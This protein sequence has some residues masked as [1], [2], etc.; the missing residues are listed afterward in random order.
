MAKQ[1]TTL[2]EALRPKDWIKNTFVFAGAV[3]T[4][5]VLVMDVLA[6]VLAGFTLFSF[7][8]SAV[9]IINDLMDVEKDR[10][11]PQKAQRFCNN[12]CYD[13]CCGLRD[14]GAGRM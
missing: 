14:K 8:A 6:M 10:L 9:Y 11:Y 3:F 2:L 4:G 5:K 1:M 13:H 12:R 7:G